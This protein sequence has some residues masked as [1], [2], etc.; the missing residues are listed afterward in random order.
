MSERA[1][2]FLEEIY[3]VPRDK[4]ALVPHGIHDVPFVDPSYY[5]DK[6]GV[7]GRKVLLTFGLLS[8][9]K[10]IEQVIE[11][12]PTITANHPK[13]TYLVLGATHPAVV[14]EEGESYRLE[15]QRR[16]RELGLEAHVLFHP[17]FVE[18]DELLEYIGAADL[19][20]T[21]YLNMDQITSGALSYAM[22]A[23]K[24]VVSTP[25]WHAEELLAEGRGTLVPPKDPKALASAIAH[26]IGDEVALAA[27][28]KRAYLYCRSM[29][30]SA[31]AQSYLKLF[32]EVRS[33]APLSVPMATAVSHTIAPS[34]IPQPRLDHLLGLSDDTGPAHH[35]RR[36]V[37]DWRFGYRLENAATGLVVATRFHSSFGSA[38]AAS[39]A[40]RCL[41]LVQ[42]LAA[43]QDGPSEGLDYA[44]NRL[45]P[46]SEAAVGKS[47]W[48]VGFTVS[49][50]KPMFAEAAYDI[51]D[52]LMPDT[53][54]ED[55]R[56]TAY[57]ALGAANY[58]DRFPGA[59]GVRRGLAACADHLVGALT[60][61][62]WQARWHGED[63]GV[64]A[65]ALAIS[66][67]SLDRP[68][69]LERAK[70]L[71]D[72]LRE[73]THDGTVFLKP[74]K[75]TDEEELPASATSFIEAL[76]ALYHRVADP[77]LLG[78]IRAAA[79]WF[80][81][82]NRQRTALYDFATGGCYDALSASGLNRNMGTEATLACLLALLTLHELAGDHGLSASEG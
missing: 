21:P 30:W 51:F 58:L 57:A 31:V 12:L 60:G 25:F 16:V 45:G 26:L 34:N 68:E 46:A 11:A 28:R 74:G 82:A 15:L 41:A 66:S 59:S 43:G 49:R 5:K 48:A 14:R 56:A 6:F 53:P 39:L 8:R 67:T 70:A 19:F 23:G 9:M 77:S 80:L 38:E 33:R 72:D 3:R 35:A 1:F 71:V 50:G 64:A 20:V 7:E 2:A 55:V 79:D 32:D 78:P 73:A 63:H 52:E 65:Q 37:P 17:R 22:G 10:G 81:G 42:Y 61:K 44:R 24:A 54:F 69:L 13:T 76:G 40:G 62:E 18:L 29:V 4:V 47:A 75:N 27:M 36:G